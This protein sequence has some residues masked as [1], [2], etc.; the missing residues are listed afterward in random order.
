MFKI[1]D[2][3]TPISPQFSRSTN[4]GQGAPLGGRRARVP[5]VELHSP[6]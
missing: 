3:N 1:G 5:A 4:I 6:G 2:D